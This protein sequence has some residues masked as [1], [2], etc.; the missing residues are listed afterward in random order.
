MKI[1]FVADIHFRGG[2]MLPTIARA[3]REAHDQCHDRG[4]DAIVMA[5]DLWDDANFALGRDTAAGDAVAAVQEPII[6]WT[7]SGKQWIGLPG[8]HD[9]RAC[10]RSALE[11]LRGIPGVTISDEPSIVRV[12]GFDGSCALVA[13]LPWIWNQSLRALPQ[14]RDMPQAEFVAAAS[15]MRRDLLNGFAAEWFGDSHF[16]LLAGH[17]E[18]DGSRTRYKELAPGSTQAL[19]ESDLRLAR[20]DAIAFGH[21]HLRQGAYV[22]ALVQQNFGEQ[23]NPAGFLIIDTSNGS[24]EFVSVD[25][26]RHFTVT[27]D[28]Y[29]SLEFRA[30]VD[31]VKVRDVEP[32]KEGA[33]LVALPDGVRFEKLLQPREVRRRAEGVTADS[34]T[35]DLLKTWL[36]TAKPGVEDSPELLAS[37]RRVM[38]AVP[39]Q[40]ADPLHAGAVVAI[41]EAR[42]KNIGPHVD[43][44]L[45][46]NDDVDGM[47]A[48]VGQNGS[49][50]TQLLET[51]CAV[52]YGEFPFYP[53][54][55]YDMMPEGFTGEALLETCFD[56][57]DGKRYRARRVLR[58]TAAT[59][60]QECHLFEVTPEGPE[61]TLAGPKRA[62]FET[63]LLRIVGD[64]STF[65]ATVFEGQN[66]PGS[67]IDAEPR[68]RM[69]FM[70]RLVGADQYGEA[71]NWCKIE[72]SALAGQIRAREQWISDNSTPEHH[73]RLFDAEIEL[74]E[75]T[76]SQ[77][78][79]AEYIEE[80]TCGE[81]ALR[82]GRAVV[83]ASVAA[84]AELAQRVQQAVVETRD[85]GRKVTALGLMISEA[86]ATLAAE[87]EM[88]RRA[89]RLVALRTEH[90]EALRQKE[91]SARIEAVKAGL[92]ERCAGIQREIAAAI[93]AARAET[94]S[95][96]RDLV[97]QIHSSEQMIAA[98]VQQAKHALDR[99]RSELQLEVGNLGSQ[100]AQQQTRLEG[101]ASR[102]RDM[103]ASLKTK[104]NL[105]KGV[106]CASTPLP[107]A[108]IADAVKAPAALEEAEDKLA[109]LELQIDTDDFAHDLR[110]AR[111][112]AIQALEAISDIDEGTVAI[113]ERTRR[114]ALREA[115]AAIA[116]VDDTSVALDLRVALAK[117]EAEAMS[118]RVPVAP[119]VSSIEHE[120]RTLAYVE[121][122]L[123]ALEE[124]RR[125]LA[126]QRETLAEQERMLLG[127]RE[128]ARDLQVKLDETA[129]PEQELRRIDEQLRSISESLA[130]VRQESAERAERIG[131]VRA[132]IQRSRDLAAEVERAAATLAPVRAE[133][134]RLALL[135]E[136]F[137]PKGLPQLLIDL[138]LPQIN[139]IYSDLTS[140]L[141]DPLQI[142]FTTQR[143]LR[144]GGTEE[145][146]FILVTDYAGT[147]DIKRHSCG[148]QGIQRKIVRQGLGL[149]SAHR[150][151]RHHAI[152]CVDEPTLGLD[153][154]AVPQ[155]LAII[156]RLASRFQQIWIVS[157]DAVLLQGIPTHYQLE[158]VNGQTRLVGSAAPAAQTIA[159]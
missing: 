16:H 130:G 151:G 76:S 102:G 57:A 81:S 17:A 112:A 103:I 84:R 80:L 41:R 154:K 60:S 85:L 51:L 77:Q 114:E 93:R 7:A 11:P 159:A 83:E 4:V 104:A 144:N 19:T 31:R 74:V 38:D 55:L 64:K 37:L 1:A 65:L 3:W 32:P 53:G 82:N 137:G 133:S 42:L 34:S 132:D 68:D 30:G 24:R 20:A 70:R 152:Y 156:Y 150:Q 122:D 62:D 39:F 25:A 54:P 145:G 71:A 22:G 28:Q 116:D 67:I 99:R 21:V 35:E 118:V 123:G 73:A 134:A 26:P 91:V 75:L 119:D 136:F 146:L 92:H 95:R 135:A 98:A 27:A 113:E 86:E 56:H 40:S 2:E 142:E 153:A 29:L 155:L 89:R 140:A 79:A 87:P 90:A 33:L 148:E 147:R 127:K 125:N 72:A 18:I 59:R 43:T 44:H 52:A 47:I 143:P 121:R 88:Q 128:A 49:G 129:T 50:K 66:D 141:E 139:D 23:D 109:R 149:Y 138:A 96:R 48:L 8:N 124:L 5:G 36:K 9:L 63:A 110:A 117:A 6:A 131:A 157:H 111:T 13:C 105:L 10:H 69:E 106:G 58:L 12:T 120:I 45:I 46:V 100:I 107:C 115:L 94:E 14:Y 108:L 78:F 158:R 61:R 101:S 126:A 97:G 15:E